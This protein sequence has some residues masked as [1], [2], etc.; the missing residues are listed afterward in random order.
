MTDTK[1]ACTSWQSMPSW[2][3]SSHEN[4]WDARNTKAYTAEESCHK[5]RVEYAGFFLGRHAKYLVGTRVC[6]GPN[7]HGEGR[8]LYPYDLK[9]RCVGIVVGEAVVRFCDLRLETQLASLKCGPLPDICLPPIL[10]AT[11]IPPKLDDY[12]GATIARPHLSLAP[13]QVQLTIRDQEDKSEIFKFCFPSPPRNNKYSTPLLPRC[14]T[15]LPP[16]IS[17]KHHSAQLDLQ[18]RSHLAIASGGE[19]YL[20][21]WW[22]EDIDVLLA[23]AVLAKLR[24]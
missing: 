2:D 10:F 22:A 11:G 18:W 4:R 12:M 13:K 9:N 24:S 16:S 15:K 6:F 14:A 21:R 23:S 19:G 17:K 8:S 7:K 20:N 5:Y 3:Y 1:A